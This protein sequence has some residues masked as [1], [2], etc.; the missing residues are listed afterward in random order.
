M[1]SGLAESEAVGMGAQVF[2]VLVQAPSVQ[3]YEQEPPYPGAQAPPEE[4]DVVRGRTQL[5][6]VAAGQE[7]G[8]QMLPFQVLP[9]AQEAVT[10]GVEASS[11]ESLYR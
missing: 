3:E 7:F 5:L 8:A 6:S 11:R 9:V 1:W 2:V 10:F 4:P